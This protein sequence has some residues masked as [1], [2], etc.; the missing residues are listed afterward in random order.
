MAKNVGRAVYIR[1]SDVGRAFVDARYKTVAALNAKTIAVNNESIDA[2]T[3]DENDPGGECWM[4]SVAGGTSVTIS[5]DG[6]QLGSDTPESFFQASA[7]DDDPRIVASLVIP[8]FG[9]YAGVWRVT[10]YEHGGETSGAVTF[11]ISLESD[12]SVTFGQAPA[13]APGLA[14]STG[15]NSGELDLS[16]TNLA[17]TPVSYFDISYYTGSDDPT[18]LRIAAGD[19]VADEHTLSGLTAGSRYYVRLQVFNEFG[20]SPMGSASSGLSGS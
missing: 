7:E 1:A 5:G 17:D 18:V 2:T 14:V 8:D 16:W 15:S 6:I 9:T 19:P 11:S 3:P 13:S 12:G 10:S 20:S 4:E